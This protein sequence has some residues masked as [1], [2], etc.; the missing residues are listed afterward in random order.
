MCIRDSFSGG[1]TSDPITNN[2]DNISTL[3][4][5]FNSQRLPYYHRLDVTIKKKFKF[6]NKTVL[7]VVGSVTNAYNRNNIFYVNRV[8]SEEIYQFPLLPSFGMSYKF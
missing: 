8:T 5:E 7:E 1:V 2:S 3:L 4:G 6:K